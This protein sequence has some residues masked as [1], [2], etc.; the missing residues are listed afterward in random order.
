MSVAKYPTV[1]VEIDRTFGAAAETD[2]K[3]HTFH[4]AWPSIEVNKKGDMVLSTTRTSAAIYPE[5]RL[6]SYY[7]AEPDLRS[8]VLL[9][10]GESP[11]F[12][13]SGRSY[14]YYGETTASC[15]DPSDDTA[16][17]VA[18]QFPYKTSKKNVANWSMWVGKL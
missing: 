6:S 10:A 15:V 18:S 5:V 2:P 16:I 4:Y 9:H 14:N 3:G 8:S 1:T 7:A 17:W 12:E 11:Y 13:G